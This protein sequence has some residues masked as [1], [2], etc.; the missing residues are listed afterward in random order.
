[1]QW[2]NE[3]SRTFLERGYLKDGETP[4]Q[5]IDIIAAKAEDI[6]GI[7]WF[8]AK[9]TDY[10]SK[11]FY[12]LSSPVWS[13]FG[14]SRGLPISC[15][16]SYLPDDMAGILYTA[17]EVG[18]M[19]KYWGGT[20]GYFGDLRPRGTAISNNG[21][22]SGAVHF[23]QLFDKSVD[24]VS[25]GSVRRGSFAAYLPVEHSDIMEFLQIWRE[26]NP[27]QRL[28]S[29]VTVT[30]KWLQEMKD[31]DIDKR[32]IWAEVL[33]ARNEIGYPYIFYTDNV[34]NNTADVYKDNK[35]KIYSSN[36]CTEILLP[37]NEDES[38]VCNLSS[39]NILHYDEWKDTDAVE[40]MVYFLDAVMSEFIDKLEQLKEDNP[41]AFYFMERAYNFATKNRALGLGVLGWHSYLQ[42]NMIPFDNML[43]YTLNKTIFKKIEEKAYKASWELFEMFW[44]P[45]ILQDYK[46]RNTTLL[47]IA[48]TKSS[49]YIL[50]QVSQWI[51]P[52][53]S[54][55]YVKDLA[56]IKST[57]KNPILKQLLADKGLDTKEVWS[58]IF[59]ADGSV[60]WLDLLTT[61][62]KAVFKTFFEINQYVIIEQAADRQ[63]FIDQGQ[64]L[65]LAISPSTPTSEVNKLY[66]YAHEKGI[67][68]LY[69]QNNTS[70]AQD[71]TRQSKC[72][73]CEW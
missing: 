20:A 45:E 11:G 33:T 25:Q 21:E 41:K 63:K 47:A 57:F 7:E 19:S 2:L 35:K 64:S 58:T 37:T 40:T 10:M 71:L 26:G 28:H 42:K 9:F 22:S 6:L 50:G 62:E 44:G 34:N 14:T 32:T 23:A 67:K 66:L 36:L 55:G 61:E 31:W 68:T 29:G 59:E 15:F 39:M 65:N 56:K 72:S 53:W 70:A 4:E 51:E 60:Q 18:M 27:I 49:S 69:Y 1:M 48:P 30:D 16:T 8:A 73:S 13:N 24:V 43:A 46:R 3:E 12:S 5:R 52:I 54:N 38:F 17:W